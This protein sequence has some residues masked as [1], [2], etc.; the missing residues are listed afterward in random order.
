MVGAPRSAYACRMTERENSDEEI[1][2]PLPDGGPT[3]SEHGTDADED[4]T[5]GLDDV[6]VEDSRTDR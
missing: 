1:N 4:G 2:P 6:G 5:A 3:D